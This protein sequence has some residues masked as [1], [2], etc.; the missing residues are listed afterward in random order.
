M[1][2]GDE[3]AEGQP[4]FRS[5]LKGHENEVTI[6]RMAA[7]SVL[8]KNKLLVRAEESEIRDYQMPLTAQLEVKEGDHVMA[9]TS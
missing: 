3:V 8:E 1:A 2:E 5:T 6:A 7:T 9:G 4:L